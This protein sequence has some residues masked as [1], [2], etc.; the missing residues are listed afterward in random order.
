MAWQTGHPRGMLM[1]TPVRHS[2]TRRP[3]A[4][5][6]GSLLLLTLSITTGLLVFRVVA[7]APGRPA[8]VP[9]APRLDYLAPDF[10]LPT[11][12][13]PAT[14]ISLRSLC[15]RPVLL[16]FSCGCNK[17]KRLGKMIADASSML[18]EAMPIVIAMNP[19]GYAESRA[20]Q[21]RR[22]TGFRWP[23]LVDNGIQTSVTYNSTECPRVWLIDREGIIRYCSEHSGER[24]ERIVSDLTRAYQGL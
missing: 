2:P 3:S 18:T 7:L 24:P 13:T 5:L 11:L 15:G 12:E 4:G 22:E 8:E 9:I 10:N 17:C 23:I 1:V 6:S 21:Y 16:I 20:R 14:R 19:W